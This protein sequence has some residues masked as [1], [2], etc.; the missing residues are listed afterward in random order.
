MPAEDRSRA[1]ELVKDL[2]GPS[3]PAAD[4]AV[5]VLQAHVAALAW[6]R[7]ATGSYPAPAEVATALDGVAE[8]LRSGADERDPAP[9]LGQAAVDALASYRAA[10][11]A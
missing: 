4:R 6:V 8:L 2:F 5:A 7:D 10:G 9:V 1:E 11:A 3:D